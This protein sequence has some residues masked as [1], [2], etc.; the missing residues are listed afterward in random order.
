MS[1]SRDF[2][3]P[4][5]PYRRNRSRSHDRFTRPGPT[6][7]ASGD[8]V[9]DRD[10][11]R[12]RDRYHDRNLRDRDRDQRNERD[13]DRDH[14]RRDRDRDFNTAHTTYTSQ[15][16][17]P[18]MD[19]DKASA[20]L[21]K[22]LHQ[23]TDLMTQK[24]QLSLKRDAELKAYHKRKQ[25]YECQISKPVQFPAV[26]DLFQGSQNHHKQTLAA[27][28]KDLAIVSHKVTVAFDKYAQT[29]VRAFP[30]DEI[31]VRQILESCKEELGL[32]NVSPQSAQDQRLKKLEQR[33]ADMEEKWKKEVAALKE[34]QEKQASELAGYREGDQ[35][36]RADS[37][38]ENEQLRA[39]VT[40][41]TS[42]IADLTQRMGT[43]E[44]AESLREHANQQVG[45]L[46]ADLS[47]LEDVL[48][49]KST[50]A[51]VN[52]PGAA[53]DETLLQEIAGLRQRCGELSQEIGSLRDISTSHAGQIAALDTDV[54][55]HENLLANIDVECLDEA[56]TDYTALKSQVMAQDL[57]IE[58]FK[59]SMAKS[60]ARVAEKMPADLPAS[61]KAWSDRVLKFCATNMDEQTKKIKTLQDSIK[62]LQDT[63]SA[64]NI[65]AV[66]PASDPASTKTPQTNT[67]LASDL[68]SVA[69]SLAFAESRLTEAESKAVTINSKLGAF[70]DTV[71]EMQGSL[72]SWQDSLANLA[73][74]ADRRYRALETM[75]ESLSSQW[76]SMNTTQMAQFMLDH[77]SS[78]QPAQL[79][80][81]ILHFHERLSNVERVIQEDGEQRKNLSMRMNSVCDDIAKAPKRGLG[82]EEKFPGPQDKRLRIE[83]QNGVN[84]VNGYG[85]SYVHSSYPV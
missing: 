39:Q 68:E 55:Q 73:S 82:A 51:E 53:Q 10:R 77:L 13:R 1:S 46:R 23:V 15:N 11:E 41:L 24:T 61:F 69:S 6:H 27:I 38:K 50:K 70:Q 40:S 56:M 33:Q 63:A 26:H 47:K 37:V 7:T 43:F 19:P 12:D 17:A 79:V 34:I 32:I 16:Q 80:P 81:E 44:P 36:M 30:I 57:L 59:Q 65:V 48:K 8:Y 42:K 64:A 9:K 78:L 83:G 67:S 60:L 58:D 21:S 66:A 4:F 31:K 76:N 74:Q 28:D 71:T 14:D 75:I 20:D 29:L 85:N 22:V 52:N 3:A 84:G 49:L 25:D 54:K 45:S 2:N 72:T 62:S 5:T 18:K 35:K